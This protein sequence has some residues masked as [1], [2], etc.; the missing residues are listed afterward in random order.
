MKMFLKKK[1]QRSHEKVWGNCFFQ[2]TREQMEL[3]APKMRRG[4]MKRYALTLGN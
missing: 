1:K 4:K 3:N 2:I